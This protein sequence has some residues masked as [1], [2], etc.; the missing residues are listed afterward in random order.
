M[1]AVLLP[2][3]ATTAAARRTLVLATAAGGAAA[4]AATHGVRLLTPAADVTA[5]VVL[6]H[7]AVAGAAFLAA[8]AWFE[9]R[10]LRQVAPLYLTLLS[11]PRCWRWRTGSRRPSP[12]SPPSPSS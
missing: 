10:S 2:F 4:I 1:L 11:A 8:D 3:R 6:F 12:S 5:A 9:R 7:V